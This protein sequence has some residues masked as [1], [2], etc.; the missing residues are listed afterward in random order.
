MT[1]WREILTRQYLPKLL[2]LA[3]AVWLH[4]AN[5]MLAATTMPSAA[6]EIGGLD[7]ISWAF[8]LYLTGSIVAAASISLVASSSLN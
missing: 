6:K 8:A 5:S 2:V 4:A 1:M 7:L 3:M